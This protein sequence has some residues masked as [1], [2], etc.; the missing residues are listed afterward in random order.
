MNYQPG[1]HTTVVFAQGKQQ[2]DEVQMA[3]DL[4]KVK[5][6]NKFKITFQFENQIIRTVIRITYGY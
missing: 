4:L 6:M 1:H 2:G 3:G 5:N